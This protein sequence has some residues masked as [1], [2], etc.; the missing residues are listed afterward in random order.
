[1]CKQIGDGSSNGDG[2]IIVCLTHKYLRIIIANLFPFFL[3]WDDV[4][5]DDDEVDWF[6]KTGTSYYVAKGKKNRSIV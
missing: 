6:R 5:W 3:S 4:E 2:L 1:M